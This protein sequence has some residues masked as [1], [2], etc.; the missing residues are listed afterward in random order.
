MFAGTMSPFFEQLG[1]HCQIGLNAKSGERGTAL[2]GHSGRQIGGVEIGRFL[3]LIP[4]ILIYSPF[5]F[6]IVAYRQWRSQE[7][8][9]GVARS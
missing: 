7:F 4:V 8:A 6:F 9:K 1:F 3:G 2:K 5:D